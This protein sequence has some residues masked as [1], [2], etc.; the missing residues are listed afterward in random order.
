MSDMRF[1]A[2]V[3][4]AFFEPSGRAVFA[5]G[6]GTVRFET[7]ECIGAHP[8]AA[9]QCAVLHPS[10]DGVI[11][12]GDD[13]RLVWSRAG[14]APLELANAAGRWI[15][16]VAANAESGLIAF[17]AGRRVQVLDSR[18]PGF[19]RTFE[20]D[21]SVADVTFDGKG[22]RLACATYGGA[23]L[24]F[25]RIEGQKPTLLKWAGSH[26][27]AA[28]SPDGRFL[29]TAMQENAL[30]GWRVADARDMRMGGY[31]AKPRSLAFLSRGALL[32][33]S[34]AN[35]VVVWQFSGADGPMGREASEVGHD[36]SAL[37]TRVAATPDG[38]RMAAGLDDG[39]VWAAALDRTGVIRL[40]ADKGAPISALAM[41]PDQTRLAWGDEDGAAGVAALP[42]GDT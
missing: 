25:A 23:A 38:A 19:L 3:T 13:E 16:A 1:D 27:A 39:R 5:L 8:D 22:R 4:S 36:D 37:V 33:T 31:P 15:D 20:H 26:I 32:A 14:A 18:D 21:R 17:A 42:F 9:V 34:G 35:G 11:T 2:Y 24:W 12:G 40:R 29:I 10:G 6:D 30:H 7:G 28:Y 41:S